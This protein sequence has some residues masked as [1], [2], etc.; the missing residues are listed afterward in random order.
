[1]HDDGFGWWGLLALVGVVACLWHVRLSP[2]LWL[3]A[4]GLLGIPLS[5]ALHAMMYFVPCGAFEAPPALWLPWA[6]RGCSWLAIV[7]GL[8]AALAQIR[9]RTDALRRAAEATPPL[10]GT[11]ALR[12]WNAGQ[13]P[14]S[15]DVQQPA[16]K[17]PGV[18]S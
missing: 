1:M 15:R 8:T 5:A 2:W 4:L 18:R 3:A 14:P 16:A 11:D 7:V 10:P 9:R 6:V 13:R 17:E 12:P